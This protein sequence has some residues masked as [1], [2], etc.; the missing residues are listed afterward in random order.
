MPVRSHPCSKQ[1]RSPL[2]RRQHDD[3]STAKRLEIA[4]RVVGREVLCSYTDLYILPKDRIMSVTFTK[5]VESEDSTGT[6]M[7]DRILTLHT[8]LRVTWKFVKAGK[9]EKVNTWDG[10]VI[11]AKS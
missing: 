7:E 5:T 2:D 6:V 8:K 9:G 10:V 11:G 4:S 1:R 3:F